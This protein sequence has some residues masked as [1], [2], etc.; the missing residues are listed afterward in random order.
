MQP[1]TT[2]DA[3]SVVMQKMA[4]DE[5][6]NKLTGSLDDDY[7]DESSSIAV[8]GETDAHSKQAREKTDENYDEGD[9]IACSFGDR[10]KDYREEYN[11]MTIKENTS[12]HSNQAM[13]KTYDLENLTENYDE[14][15]KITDSFGDLDEHY[16]EESNSMATKGK[17]VIPSNQTDE[18]TDSSENLVKP[19]NEGEIADILGDTSEHYP[20]E[21]EENTADLE[22]LVEIF[23]EDK[24]TNIFGDLDED[25]REES[26][27]MAIQ[28]K[29][30]AHRNQ[31][32]QTTTD[33]EHADPDYKECGEVT[34]VLSYH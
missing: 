1:R 12:F 28:G 21:S 2:P 9:E 23:N 8:K 33:S 7:H 17:S 26:N 3:D 10:N 29:S 24:I 32:K 5:Y 15:G 14:G 25:Y 27:W 4:A 13:E 19:F 30:N 34:T 20:E 11:S 18:K 31:I 6:E 16:H 22:N